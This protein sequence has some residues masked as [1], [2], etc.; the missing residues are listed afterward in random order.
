[1][2]ISLASTLK[3]S[4]LSLSQSPSLSTAPRPRPRITISC[5]SSS[6]SSP[7]TR[8]AR[9]NGSNYYELLSLNPNDTSPGDIKKAYRSLALRY[10]P[11]ACRDPSM[12]EEST[13]MF[14]WLHE[15]YETLSDP[16]SRLVYNYEL[17][18]SSTVSWGS[19]CSVV[20]GNGIFTC[21]GREM[22]RGR[23]QDQIVELKRRSNN[24]MAQK[25]GSWAARQRCQNLRRD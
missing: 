5:Q 4:Q 15:A 13:R 9:E 14:L 16:E 18:L 19:P 24:R 7:A 6:S 10:H 2:A 11:D 8:T 3:A 21:D 23:W 22:V 25:N 1:M 12:K 17:G 20:D